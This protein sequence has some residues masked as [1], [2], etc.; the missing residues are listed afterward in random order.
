MSNKKH[1]NVVHFSRGENHEKRKKAKSRAVGLQRQYPTVK[2]GS[3]P[4]WPMPEWKR[5]HN[6][7]GII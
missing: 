6:H 2:P 3:T 5:Q 4:G 7:C 1:H